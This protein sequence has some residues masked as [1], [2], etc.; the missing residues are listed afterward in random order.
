MGYN[1]PQ[2]PSAG[3]GATETIPLVSISLGG[4]KTPSDQHDTSLSTGQ[5]YVN[6][7]AGGLSSMAWSASGARGLSGWKG[8]NGSFENFNKIN[9]YSGLFEWGSES[10]NGTYMVVIGGNGLPAADLT[11]VQKHIAFF[12]KIVAGVATSWA[13]VSDGEAQT[14]VQITPTVSGRV[15]IGIV[16]T[17]N[18]D[19]K[20]YINGVLAATIDTNLPSGNSNYGYFWGG[21]NAAGDATSRINRNYGSTLII[22]GVVPA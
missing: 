21:V 18:V 11:W 14:L 15:H 20:F 17:P 6:N 7:A 12:Q 22:E 10:G 16:F 5:T 19:C 9:R 2:K 1:Q 8:F 13:S 4:G 3:G